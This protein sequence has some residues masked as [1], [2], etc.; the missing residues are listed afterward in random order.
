MNRLD[1]IAFILLA[2][3]NDELEQDDAPVEEP[4]AKPEPSKEPKSKPRK[5]VASAR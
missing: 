4:E 2:A 1:R 5:R 3:L